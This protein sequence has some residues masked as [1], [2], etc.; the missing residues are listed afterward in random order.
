MKKSI[1]ISIRVSKDELKNLGK[2]QDLKRMRHI[3]SL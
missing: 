2:Q 1:S 3:V